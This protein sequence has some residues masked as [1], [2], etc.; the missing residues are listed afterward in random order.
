MVQPQNPYKRPSLSLSLSLS[1]VIIHP[2]IP[3]NPAYLCQAEVDSLDSG[4]KTSGGIG[5][6]ISEIL[7]LNWFAMFWVSLFDLYNP[8]T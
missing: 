4:N 1:V 3:A 7:E 5:E 2:H 8:H 6:A